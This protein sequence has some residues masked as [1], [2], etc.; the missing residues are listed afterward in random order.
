MNLRNSSGKTTKNTDEKS[1]NRRR[2]DTDEGKSQSL[3]LFDEY[4]WAFAGWKE[5]R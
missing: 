2:V 1:L 5:S 4:I 3:Q